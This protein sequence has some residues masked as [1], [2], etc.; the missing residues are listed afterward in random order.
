MKDFDIH[1]IVTESGV[2]GGAYVEFQIV[3]KGDRYIHHW[4]SNSIFLKEALFSL[5]ATCL[6]NCHPNFNYYGSTK[7]E[8]EQL[9][10]LIDQF[11]A[12]K[13]QFQEINNFDSFCQ[14]V[15][16]NSFITVDNDD[17][18]LPYLL[19]R[20]KEYE[21]KWE[22]ILTSLIKV[23]QN[24]INFSETAYQKGKALLVLGV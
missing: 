6:Y 12:L 15:E 24:L 8:G 22:G 1:D 16:K 17:L 9:T 23:N 10:E 3:D 7:F 18:R 20:L 5:F 19:Y 2:K 13:M 4:Q 11:K 14:I 21:I